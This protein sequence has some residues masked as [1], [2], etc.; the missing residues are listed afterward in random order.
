VSFELKLAIEGNLV[1]YYQAEYQHGRRAVTLG[2]GD[3]IEA[4]KQFARTQ[5]RQ[6]GLGDRLAN[7]WRSRVYPNRA[8]VYSMN[9]A[10]SLYS[11]AP[12]IIDLYSRGGTIVPVHGRRYLAIPTRYLPQ[13]VPTLIAGSRAAKS[14]T[15]LTVAHHLGVKL[16]LRRNRHGTLWLE[17]G[18]L[19]LS[20]SKKAGRAGIAKRASDKMIAKGKSLT[21]PLFWLVKSA[22]VA[23]RLDLPAIEAM[24]AGQLDVNV[25]RRW[26]EDIHGV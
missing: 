3:T 11:N 4:G 21:L 22:R 26:Q 6:A 7:T 2:M 20:R 25:L 15:P 24:M 17:A 14:P 19:R 10:A 9:A 8:N 1:S 5:L 23:K 18:G 13:V 12:H 16:V